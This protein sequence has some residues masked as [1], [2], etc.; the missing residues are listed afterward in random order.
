MESIASPGSEQV[1]PTSID[2]HSTLLQDHPLDTGPCLT[3]PNIFNKI[4]DGS[5]ISVCSLNCCVMKFAI[6]HSLTYKAIDDLLDLLNFVCPKPNLLPSSIYKL[7]QFFKQYESQT[8]SK[9]YCIKCGK[10]YDDCDCGQ[11]DSANIGHLVNISIDKP[12]QAVL[13]GNNKIIN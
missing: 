6:K 12:L 2:S 4:Y 3:D 9:R 10:L 7:K 8:S 1:N 5:T 13:S 11:P